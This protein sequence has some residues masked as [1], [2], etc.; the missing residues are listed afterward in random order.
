MIFKTSQKAAKINTRTLLVTKLSGMLEISLPALAWKR[1][2][3]LRHKERLSLDQRQPTTATAR[4]CAEPVRL[5]FIA[6]SRDMQG[7]SIEMATAWD[8]NS[9]HQGSRARLESSCTR[10][11]IT[12]Q[13]AGRKSPALRGLAGSTVSRR[14]AYRE[15]M[16]DWLET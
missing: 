4:Q 14:R 10:L 5:R 11:K 7:I 12:C 2:K 3:R 6:A 9:D 1:P 16:I 13:H 15:S 8:A